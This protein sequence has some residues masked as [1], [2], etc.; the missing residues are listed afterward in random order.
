[1]CLS[2]NLI[3][4]VTEGTAHTVT[5]NSLIESN[6][7]T[8]KDRS[9]IYEGHKLASSPEVKSSAANVVLSK[10]AK[11]HVGTRG[12]NRPGKRA[13]SLR[14][15]QY[16]LPPIMHVITRNGFYAVWLTFSP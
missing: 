10:A 2:H 6:K 3:C 11:L 15:P 16:K 13:D 14:Q 1:M 4:K 7:Q 9:G 8:N 5:V 12:A